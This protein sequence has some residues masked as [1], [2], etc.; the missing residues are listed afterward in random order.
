MNTESLPLA[1]NLGAR[2]QSDPRAR[3]DCDDDTFKSAAS[4]WDRPRV[5]K[6]P[7]AKRLELQC[8]GPRG[9]TG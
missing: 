9:S 4:I 6:I 5:T 2:V 7:H 1:G 3:K 8:P